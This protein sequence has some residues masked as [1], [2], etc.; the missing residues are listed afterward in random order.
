MLSLSSARDLAIQSIKQA[1]IKYKRV[2]DKK[3]VP[4]QLQVGDWVLV[5]FPQDEV[6]KM[7]KLSCPWHGPYRILLKEGPMSRYSV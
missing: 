3:S 4:S 5:R 7:R 6:G 2:Y 1:Q